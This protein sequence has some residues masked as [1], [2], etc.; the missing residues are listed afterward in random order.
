M[1]KTRGVAML[2]NR[3]PFQVLSLRMFMCAISAAIVRR[4][5][6]HSSEV[7]KLLT[8][9]PALSLQDHPQTHK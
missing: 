3:G 8:Q 4:A 5:Y 7:S 6:Y 2:L 1:V 9:R